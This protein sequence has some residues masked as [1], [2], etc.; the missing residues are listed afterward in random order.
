[1]KIAFLENEVN[2]IMLW[3]LVITVTQMIAQRDFFLSNAYNCLS[4]QKMQNGN[5]TTF[6]G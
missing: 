6:T 3:V 4:I 2:E 1:M 5:K